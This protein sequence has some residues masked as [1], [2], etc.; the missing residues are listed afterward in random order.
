MH[1]C[2]AE[3]YLNWFTADDDFPFFIQYGK[4]DTDLYIHSHKDFNELV[5]VIDGS[6]VHM[7]N[8][9]EYIIKKGDVFVVGNDT[10]HGYKN[11]KSFRICN[12]MYR[13]AEMFS[14]AP[15]IAASAG[16][17]ALFVL[18]PQ[19][20]KEQGFKNRLKIYRENYTAVKFILDDMVREYENMYECAK[21]ML[22]SQFIR[23]A[24]VLSRLYSFDI[25]GNE[26][27]VINI[28]KAVSYIEN[29]FDESIS[30]A[31]LAEL[32]Y[33][34]E[35]HF[36][37]IFKNAYDCSPIEYIINMRINRACTLLKGSDMTISETAEKCGFDDVN[38]FSR[39]FKKKVGVSP[40]EF[41][42]KYRANRYDQ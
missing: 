29:H 1:E 30:V 3:I 35:R 38:Y 4:H 42:K 7:V 5:I 34:S 28:A 2:A 8:N 19:I 24:V 9:E 15:D 39:L 31:K 25:N 6:A 23:L 10:V 11:T 20:T 36:M 33:Y 14:A 26:H 37:R 27:D 12:I 32:S 22:I 13:H 17:Q 16:Y 40:S 18:E 21:S 41:R